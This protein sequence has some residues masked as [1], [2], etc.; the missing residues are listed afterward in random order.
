MER[1]VL[2]E[3]IEGRTASPETRGQAGQEAEEPAKDHKNE[4]EVVKRSRKKVQKRRQPT[5]LPNALM[6]RAKEGKSY[7]D[8]MKKM[9]LGVSSE[10]VEI[11]DKVRRTTTGQLLIVLGE[12]SAEKTEKL[13]KLMSETLKEDADV[14]SRTQQ[15]N[16]EIRDLE[17]TATKEEITEALNKAAGEDSLIPVEAV[18]SLRK[19]YGET[20]IADVRLDAETARKI[21]GNEGRIR[22]GWV[23]CRIKEVKRPLKCFKCWH[24]GHLSSTCKSETDRSKQCIKC[25]EDGHKVAECKNAPLCALCTEKKKELSSCG[26]VAGS[27]RCA[28]YQQALVALTNNRR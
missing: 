1:R 3:G 9:K 12:K 27:I 5:T 4:W 25:G 26:H 15:V 28:V 17:E 24:Y 11:I 6:I 16:L 22:I 2:E 13:R 18:K 23:R 7:A 8:I 14:S 21:I 20:Q 10:E 19:T